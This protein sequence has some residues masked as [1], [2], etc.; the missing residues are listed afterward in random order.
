MWATDSNTEKTKILQFSNNVFQAAVT[1]MLQ[2]AIM[3][4]PEQI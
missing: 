1:K 3:N 2:Q 4:T